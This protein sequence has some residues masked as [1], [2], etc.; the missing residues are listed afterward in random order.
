MKQRKLSVFQ[1]DPAARFTLGLLGAL[2][3]TVAAAAIATSTTLDAVGFEFLVLGGVGLAYIAL[4]VS[5]RLFE[6]S[7]QSVTENSSESRGHAAR[8]SSDLRLD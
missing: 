8:H 2:Q 4:A 1:R 3:A 6:G 7:P 5:G